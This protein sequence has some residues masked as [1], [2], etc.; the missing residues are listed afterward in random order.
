M[1]TEDAQPQRVRSQV[2][3]ARKQKGRGFRERMD[4]DDE[5]NGSRGY[6]SLELGSG[7]GPA[8]CEDPCWESW[9]AVGAPKGLISGWYGCI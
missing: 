7:P 4:V 6:E 5:R 1:D 8:K 3:A 9:G 2:N